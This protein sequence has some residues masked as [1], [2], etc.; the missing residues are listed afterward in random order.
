MGQEGRQGVR[1][2]IEWAGWG[3]ERQGANM[4]GD[5][6]SSQKGWG[7]GQEGHGMG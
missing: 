4:S 1:R 5:G 3:E 2:D 7:M 6:T